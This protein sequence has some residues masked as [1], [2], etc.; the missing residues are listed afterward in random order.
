MHDKECQCVP[1]Q[2]MQPDEYNRLER[3]MKERSE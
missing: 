1:C 2:L 3:Y